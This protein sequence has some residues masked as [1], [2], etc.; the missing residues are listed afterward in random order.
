MSLS[1]TADYKE[2]L[3]GTSNGCLYRVL[4]EDLS[5]MLHTEGH[6]TGWMLVI[7]K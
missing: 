2:L 1:I 6:V 7:E 3:A 5:S 4:T